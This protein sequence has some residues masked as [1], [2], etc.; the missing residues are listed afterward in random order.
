MSY[1]PCTAWIFGIAAMS[2]LQF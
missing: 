1:T 2:S